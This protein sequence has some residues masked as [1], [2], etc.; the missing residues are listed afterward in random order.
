LTVE[1]FTSHQEKPRLK[2]KMLLLLSMLS[3]GRCA[4]DGVAVRPPQ[5]WRDWNQY[6][7]SISQ[8]IMETSA[9]A[10]ASTSRGVSLLSLG[11][12]DIGVDDEWQLCGA[13]GKFNYTY[14]DELGNPQV[15]TTKFPNMSGMV[16]H[17]HSLGMTAG[18]YSNNCHCRDH[19]TDL[20]C[21]AGDVNAVIQWGFDS[22][23]LDGCGAQE[24]VQLW[25]DSFDWATKAMNRTQLLIENCHNGPVRFFYA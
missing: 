18:F 10:V 6:Q 21:F 24:N 4:D 11:Y 9:D 22:I 14:H 16:S 8:Q 15:D 7:G 1:T 3:G 12:S 5:G 25:Y 23:K 17:I 19:C 20:K 2:M 13:Y